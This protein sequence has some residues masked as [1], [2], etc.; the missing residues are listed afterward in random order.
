MYFARFCGGLDSYGEN[1]MDIKGILQAQGIQTRIVPCEIEV[2]FA[3]AEENLEA[4]RKEFI[5]L[6][7]HRYGSITQ[8]LNKNKSKNRLE[9][10]D[11]VLLELLVELYQKVE[12]IEQI[13]LNKSFAYVSLS[14]EGIANFVGHS[15]LCMPENVFEKGQEY[16]LRIFLNAF[17]KRYVG[18]FAKA[19]DERIVV[20]TQIHQS[21]VVDFDSFVVQMERLMILDSKS[22]LK[23][24][25]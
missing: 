6:S 4:Y 19:I 7:Q 12:N 15:V 21:D 8:W 3:K 24:V 25:E 1:V 23:G 17:P 22:A 16:Y 2:A 14:G 5:A 11:E 10:T 18:I 20:F 13:L 9:D